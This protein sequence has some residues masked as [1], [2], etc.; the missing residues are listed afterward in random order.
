M[1]KLS[2]D[3]NPVWCGLLVCGY[4]CS[5]AGATQVCTRRGGWMVFIHNAPLQ[6]VSCDL[7]AV[8]LQASSQ[9]R[10]VKI[11]CNVVMSKSFLQNPPSKDPYCQGMC[12][13]HERFA[14]P[15]LLYLTSSK[16]LTLTSLQR[17]SSPRHLS[18]YLPV[19]VLESGKVLSTAHSATQEQSVYNYD[20][21]PS[22]GAG[23]EGRRVS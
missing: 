17:L 10:V 9:P 18:S 7:G 1:V 3:S 20:L 8:D 11:V 5:S 14:T 23:K 19:S 12:L 4:R 16:A 2:L 13:Q 15:S 22:I 21:V 6:R